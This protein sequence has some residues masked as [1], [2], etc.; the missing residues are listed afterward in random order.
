MLE[1]ASLRL[2]V[3]GLSPMSLVVSVVV[4]VNNEEGAAVQVAREIDTVF[5]GT[6]GP[7]QYE[8]IFV[9]DKSRDATLERLQAVRAE[10]PRLRII[11]H[12]NNTGKSGGVRTGVL[13][14]RGDIIAML[15]GDGQNPAADVLK[16][17][18][19]LEASAPEVGMVAGERRNR[20]DNQSKRLASRWANNIRKSMLNDGSNDTG[21][22]IKAIRRHVFLRLPYFDNMHRYMPALVTREGFLTLFQP[23]EDRLRTTGQSKYTNIGRLLE[24]LTDLPGVM[25]LNRRYRNPGSTTEV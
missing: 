19:V 11:R 8:I 2:I 23:V 3:N 21:C 7:D 13:N 18:T 17:T 20:Q 25:W 24:A 1:C 15:D 5:A 6:Y 9:D 16:V 22:G 14:A 12:Q 10:L 4:A